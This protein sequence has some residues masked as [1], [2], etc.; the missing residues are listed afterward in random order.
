MS[1][2]CYAYYYIQSEKKNSC[3]LKLKEIISVLEKCSELKQLSQD[4]YCNTDTFPWCTISVVH[5]VG[6]CYSTIDKILPEDSPMNHIAI[7]CSKIDPSKLERCESLFCHIARRLDWL[8]YLEEDDDGNQDVK[9][10]N[11]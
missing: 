1:G 9:I 11:S 2:Q 10:L 4:T 6:G 8:L 7:V 3:F 5:Q